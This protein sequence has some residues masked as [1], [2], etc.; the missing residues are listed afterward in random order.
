VR[1]A[2]HGLSGGDPQRVTEA[3]DQALRFIRRYLQGQE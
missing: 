2:G 3:H 1:G